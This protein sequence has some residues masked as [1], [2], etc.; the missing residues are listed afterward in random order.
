MGSGSEAAGDDITS[1]LAAKDTENAAPR[2][3]NRA[4]LARLTELE[5][6]VAALRA[7]LGRDSSNSGRPPSSDSPSVKKPAPKRSIRTRSG[8]PQGKQPGASS[9]TPRLVDDPDDTITHS[10]PVC[11]GC[12]EGL[13][14]AEIF[15]VCRHQI[16]DVPRPSP[17]A[18]D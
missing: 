2:S 4:L 12:G 13:A 10:P 5:C 8:K 3:E 7:Q 11:A 1:L 9:A 17:T 14:D 18:R 15:G 6:P 16:F